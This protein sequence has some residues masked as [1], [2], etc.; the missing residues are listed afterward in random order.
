MTLPKW[1][2]T[3][4]V[5]SLP[6]WE[7]TEDFAEEAAPE[8]SALD[9]VGQTL[10]DL[11]IGT[12]DTTVG[13][14]AAGV[15]SGVVELLSRYIDSPT[16][17]KLRAEGFKLPEEERSKWDAFTE[18]Y[19]GGKESLKGTVEEARERSPIATTLGSVASEI[20]QSA[21]P[22]SKLG[23]V[24][25]SGS[26]IKDVA[27]LLGVGAVEGSLAEMSMGDARLL[28]G[29]VAG[30]L[31]EAA[32][33]AALGAVGAGVGA[34]ALPSLLKGLGVVGGAKKFLSRES[35]AVSKLQDVSRGLSKVYSRAK[36]SGSG[37]VEGLT[38]EVKGRAV[39]LSKDVVSTVRKARTEIGTKIGGMRKLAT[40]D[41]DV[42]LR[43]SIE[44][45]DEV[46]GEFRLKLPF[47]ASKTGKDLKKVTDY[48]GGIKSE[49][50]DLSKVELK[51]AVKISE[52][53]KSMTTNFMDGVEDIKDKEL[54][55]IMRDFSRG[56][57]DIVDEKVMAQLGDKFPDR[58]EE[59]LKFKQKYG[60]LSDLEA[61]TG[62]T[63]MSGRVKVKSA[64][65]QKAGETIVNDLAEESDNVRSM[66]KQKVIRDT[67]N[68]AGLGKFADHIDRQIKEITDGIQAIQYINPQGTGAK[69]SFWRRTTAITAASAGKISGE[70]GRALA[71]VTKLKDTVAGFIKG[72]MDN[73]QALSKS[74]NEWMKSAN[75]KHMSE[76]GEALERAGKMRFSKVL[77]N[78]AEL[79]DP[80][81][82]AIRMHALMQ[83]PAFR[84]DLR[85]VLGLEKK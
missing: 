12:A 59:Y 38:K 30:T 72:G 55:A 15:S 27:K 50:P 21:A 47:A 69:T 19:Y 48:L 63:T 18:G 78:M 20:S 70:T 46:L 39:S 64:E 28:E 9:T 14:T 13:R 36:R 8:S 37:G 80:V 29:D 43:D 68:D 76:L 42:G 45:I 62:T 24:G 23:L 84:Q 56:I 7:E 54:L 40:E 33:G 81:Q 11:L 82:K 79:K 31:G 32:E 83:Q 26:K 4:E 16:D 35:K 2:D 17:R 57:D 58:V 74:M 34:A 60:S 22:V 66:M 51:R 5:E 49:V 52:E 75:N 44:R 73:T 1:E 25:K 65:L 61:Y 77:K 3:E 6:T 10:Q 67:L 85:S 41:A 71:P 53:L